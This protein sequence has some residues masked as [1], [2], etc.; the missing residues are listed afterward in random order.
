VLTGFVGF[1][2]SFGGKWFGSYARD[3]AGTNY[4]LQSKRSLL[5]DMTALSRAQFMCSDYRGVPIPYGAVVYADPPYNSTTG[6][7]RERF[8]SYE[9]WNYARLIATTGH[10]LF[11]SEQN[12]PPD[13]EAIWEKPF[14]RTLD[15]NKSNQFKVTEKLFVYKGENH[16]KGRYFEPSP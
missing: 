13:F 5:K 2:C 7:N 10:L 6:Y 1:G 4:A 12:A 8:D 3:K 11:V 15:A 16:D 9:F 14:T